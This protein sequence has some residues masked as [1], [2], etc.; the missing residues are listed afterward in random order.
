MRLTES[1]IELMAIEQLE[2]MGYTYVYGP[3]NRKLK[4]SGRIFEI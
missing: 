2:G 1:D 3:D 4:K